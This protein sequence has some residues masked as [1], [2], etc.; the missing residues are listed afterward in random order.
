[1][2]RRQRTALARYAVP[3]VG[4]GVAWRV[5][6]EPSRYTGLGVM[7]VLFTMFWLILLKPRKLRRARMAYRHYRDGRL[8]S[9]RSRAAYRKD[10]KNAGYERP[11]I[12]VA[13]R[14]AVYAADWY[15]CV[16]C[17]SGENLQ[18]DHYYPWSLG[19]L[20]SRRNCFTLCR[21]CNLVKSNYWV[22]PDQYVHY[23]PIENYDN[24]PLAAK[25]LAAERRRRG[26]LLRRAR[27]TL[28]A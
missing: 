6:H 3:L 7:E 9:A 22:D 16:Y 17:G 24:E 13:L 26:S 15:R 2:T 4:A 25:I 23:R 19:G 27:V 8:V 12:P 18:I 21:A 14:R 11:A 28:A 5:L 10:R 20:T 1:M